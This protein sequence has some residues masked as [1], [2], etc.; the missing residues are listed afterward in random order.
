MTTLRP[1]GAWGWPWG[2]ATA[3]TAASFATTLPTPTTAKI[4]LGNPNGVGFRS[5]P[6]VYPVRLDPPNGQF[7]P[8]GRG[9]GSLRFGQVGTGH[10]A[11]PHPR[12]AHRRQQH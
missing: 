4:H 11:R 12:R 3:R 2:R 9:V 6:L 5:D 10:V 7:L 8:I 1:N